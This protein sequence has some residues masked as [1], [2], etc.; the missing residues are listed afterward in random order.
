MDRRM[1]DSLTLARDLH[2]IAFGANERRVVQLNWVTDEKVVRREIG[3]HRWS[4]RIK[5]LNPFA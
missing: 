2:H 4:A 1:P 3:R 5:S